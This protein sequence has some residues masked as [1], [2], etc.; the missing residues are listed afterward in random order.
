MN[1][2]LGVICVDTVDCC[3]SGHK[4]ESLTVEKFCGFAKVFQQNVLSPAIDIHWG[5]QDF[6][7]MVKR[8]GTGKT[9]HQK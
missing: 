5:Y 6:P 2:Q 7:Q 9:F 8:E 1:I 3:R 4:V